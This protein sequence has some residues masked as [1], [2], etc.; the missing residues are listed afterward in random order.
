MMIFNIVLFFLAV[1][2][3]IRVASSIKNKKRR[4][5]ESVVKAWSNGEK[6]ANAL[7]RK[8]GQAAVNE[9]IKSNILLSIAVKNKEGS[10]SESF[11]LAYITLAETVSMSYYIER[12]NNP[13]LPYYY[14]DNVIDD[15][16]R[17]EVFAIFRNNE[18]LEKSFRKSLNQETIPEEHKEDV[19]K[20]LVFLT[21]ISKF[22]KQK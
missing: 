13:N 1:I 11:E 5:R 3:V 17:K 16:V 12:I 14:D 4:I 15:Y 9:Q 6:K 2:I 19:Y 7:Y 22:L 20:I 10:K 8:D 21:E 18:K